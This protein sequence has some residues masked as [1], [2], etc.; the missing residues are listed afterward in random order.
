MKVSV[1]CNRQ[2]VL[3]S[4]VVINHNYCQSVKGNSVGQST[5]KL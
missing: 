1:D 4:I 3:C 5:V 2:L